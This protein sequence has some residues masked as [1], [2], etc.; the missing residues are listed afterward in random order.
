MENC[1]LYKRIDEKS[2][3]MDMKQLDEEYKNEHLYLL[4]NIK[5]VRIFKKD[6]ISLNKRNDGDLILPSINR[7]NAVLI[8]LNS[9]EF[10]KVLS[11]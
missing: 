11:Q 7:F 6:N 4:N 1:R 5:K 3:F 2:P 10:T 9:D 8:Y